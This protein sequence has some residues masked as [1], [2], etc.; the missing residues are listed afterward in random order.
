MSRPAG[1]QRYSIQ[2]SYSEA[3]Q[4]WMADIP[5]LPFC[6]AFGHSPREALDEVERAL[7]AWLRAAKAQTRPLPEPKLGFTP[8][9]Y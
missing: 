5:D 1:P 6:T 8:S 9:D 3:D 2:I 4:G 7:A